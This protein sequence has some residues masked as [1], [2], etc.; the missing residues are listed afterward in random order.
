MDGV[1]VAALYH[2][3]VK[4]CRGIALEA[5]RITPY[6]LERDR[7]WMVVD[8]DGVFLSQR[9][10][11]AMALIEAALSDNAL[12]LRAPGMAEIVV[13]EAQAVRPLA[14]RV[15]D[16]GVT[17]RDAG[18]DAAAWLS[19]Y[20]R[21]PC[22]LAALG[23]E[24]RRPVDPDYDRHDTQVA[25]SDGFPFLLLSQASLADLN[26]R[27]AR[28]LPMNRFR[29]NIVVSGCPPYAEDGWKTLRI[30][31]A[32]FHVVKPCSRC[33][34]TTTDQ[35][36]GRVGKEPLR[37]LASYRRGAGGKVYFGQNLIHETRH[38]VLRVGDG[39]AVLA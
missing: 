2:Y 21:Q 32:L 15:W 24:L 28:P 17:A 19:D 23:P 34:I 30:G 27:L 7:Q 3:P 22:R 13:P 37:T 20:L 36:T 9:R 14:V 31:E 1:R 39:V 10:L 35:M 11:P 33:A 8:G 26:S 38:G 5:A 4:S 18:D 25:F 29:P 16:D 6:G 12:L